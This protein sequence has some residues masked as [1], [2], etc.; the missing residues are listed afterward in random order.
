MQMKNGYKHPA[1]LS[2]GESLELTILTRKEVAK[3]MG[4][5]SARVHQ[6]EM[7]ALQKLKNHPVLQQLAA[8]LGIIPSNEC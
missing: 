2:S 5:S 4:I 7:R 8:D 3:R 6:I 1:G